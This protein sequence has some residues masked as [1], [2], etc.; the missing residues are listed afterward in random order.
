LLAI[1]SFPGFVLEGEMVLDGLS[2]YSHGEDSAFN[3]LLGQ[4]PEGIQHVFRRDLFDLGYSLIFG[5]LGDET[6]GS[7]R[8]AT[9]SGGESDILDSVILHFQPD[10]HDIP[11]GAD[12]AGIAIGIGDGAHVPG[13]P[14]M[15]YDCLA[16]TCKVL[17]PGIIYHINFSLDKV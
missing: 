13:V 7:Y 16:E 3:V 14:S 5:K 1:H 12:G 15:V 4:S 11:T 17:F 8:R 10:L 9:A 2:E 6:Q